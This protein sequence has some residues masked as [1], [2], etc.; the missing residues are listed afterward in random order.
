[1]A[2]RLSALP[3]GLRHA[4]FASARPPGFSHWHT[5]SS[6]SRLALRTRPATRPFS[7]QFF[8]RAPG[9]IPFL[10]RKLLWL[11][12]VAGGLAFYASPGAPSQLLPAIFASPTLI[13]CP[14]PCPSTADISPT[15]LS[16]AEPADTRIL[17]RICVFLNDYVWEPV[18]TT[19]RFIYLVWLFFPVLFTAPMLLVG[20]PEDRLHGD[21][22]GAVWW[23]GYLTSQM[24]KAGPTFIKVCVSFTAS[25]A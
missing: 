25:G 4:V 14:A 20:R 15:I 8:T 3:L 1:M 12:P 9:P 18:L 11:V 23:Y 16:P 5:A 22:W 7:T 17:V 13:P 2:L 6:L 21:K 19:R 10:G 24:Q